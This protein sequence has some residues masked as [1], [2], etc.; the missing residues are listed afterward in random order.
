M[1][2]F[3][4]ILENFGKIEKN[5]PKVSGGGSKSALLRILEPNFFLGPVTF[6]NMKIFEKK[7]FRPEINP[8]SRCEIGLVIIGPLTL[9]IQPVAKINFS[10]FRFFLYSPVKAPNAVGVLRRV[11]FFPDN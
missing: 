6:P 9:E 2:M 7:F 3:W 10:K 8:L 11:F 1:D 5:E 4:E